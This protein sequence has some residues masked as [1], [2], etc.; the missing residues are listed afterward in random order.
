[1][2]IPYSSAV[3][4]QWSAYREDAAARGEVILPLPYLERWYPYFPQGTGSK[5]NDILREDWLGAGVGSTNEN[6][7]EEPIAQLQWCGMIIPLDELD[8]LG[9]HQLMEVCRALEFQ[10]QHTDWY[11]YLDR[12]RLRAETATPAEVVIAGLWEYLRT[13]TALL[14]RAPRYGQEI[15][16]LLRT[17][18]GETDFF[19]SLPSH[20]A[21]SLLLQYAAR[22]FPEQWDELAFNRK[23]ERAAPEVRQLLADRM[24]IGAA[25]EGEDS[26]RLFALFTACCQA[27][28]ALVTVQ[29]MLDDLSGQSLR[30]RLPADYRQRLAAIAGDNL[31]D[32]LKRFVGRLSILDRA[33]LSP[34]TAPA[35]AP[36][37]YPTYQALTS[38]DGPGWYELDSEELMALLNLLGGQ[39]EVTKAV[40]SRTIGQQRQL[41]CH[42][43]APV[44][45]WAVIAENCIP[46]W[47]I[48]PQELVEKAT[49][50]HE[51]EQRKLRQELDRVERLIPQLRQARSL[52]AIN[53][54]ERKRTPFTSGGA[55]RQWR[56]AVERQRQEI[57][58]RRL[59][60]QQ[61][62]KAF[63]VDLADFSPSE[64]DIW[65][66]ELLRVEEE[67]MPYMAYVR[68]AFQAALPVGS[69]VEFNPFRHRSD[70]VEFDPETIQDQDKWL[71]G[72]V[73]KTLRSRREYAP[74]TQVNAFCLDY[75]RSMHHDLMRNLFKVV[76]LL[77]TGLEGRDTY[78]AIHFFGSGFKEAV[79]F[80]DADGFTSRK[81][82][83]RILA[84]I[85][86]I[87]LNSVV[88]SGF[89]GTNISDAVVKS[90]E[91][92]MA[93]SR[94]LERERP[95]VRYVRSI[96]ILTD[97]QPT[98]GVINLDD[99]RE[100]VAEHRQAGDVSIKGI[101]LK[102]PQ[103]KS[104]FIT[105]IF[106]P[107]HA[108]EATN[109]DEL[110]ATFVQT[111][112]LT[113]RQQ[114]KD[115]R[116]AQRRKK[117]L[118]LRRKPD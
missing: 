28:Q 43:T 105:R 17:I 37:F 29:D 23:L 91:K 104:D 21:V 61:K 81:A 78:D 60:R 11:A 79:D 58:N 73:M 59:F 76:F 100:L 48:A 72:E 95:D 12:T 85:A 7:R 38:T 10:R 24:A 16:P 49:L 68:R 22:H 107:R 75:S 87:K 46:Q 34:S 114:R 109:F 86:T 2:A 31:G 108:V 13:Y 1:M 69:T 4:E 70:G 110:I 89:G 36:L 90:H 67:V 102:H 65:L 106:G 88:Y 14:K 44:L 99:L 57:F 47:A 20:Q 118:G 19:G 41:L 97:G 45:D 35:S 98:V 113:Y 33:R 77:V 66:D 111:M 30:S 27:D 9:V 64:K 50:A 82:L 115:Y 80:T 32:R 96:L 18:P 6:A 54:L 42:L 117:L 103:D 52:V 94:Q 83:G 92:I 71:R 56:A 26:P 93:F 63:G 39:P 74:I 8:R 55:N 62:M 51:E 101:Y 112:S 25:L 40:A 3:R 15:G 53:E 116:Q 84:K 5:A